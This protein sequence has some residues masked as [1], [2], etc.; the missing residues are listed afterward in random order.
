MS[1][2]KI[3][4]IMSDAFIIGAVVLFLGAFGPVLLGELS[5]SAAK[6][7]DFGWQL[8]VGN[9]YANNTSSNAVGSIISH[10]P[11]TLKPA[12]LDSSIVIEKIGVSAPVVLNV[13]VTDE[14]AYKEALKYGVAHAKGSALPGENGNAYIFAHSSINFWELGKY[15]TVFNLLNKLEAGD[16]IVLFYN[17]QRFDYEV[18]DNRVV[19]GWNT[20]PI[21][22]QTTYPILTLQTCDPPGT[23]INRRIVTAKLVA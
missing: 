12:N 16:R 17:K 22:R 14:A 19:S 23:V 15:A 2:S 20:L 11:L 13:P 18:V 4:K 9:D 6:I 10:K 7:F 5:Y 8:P 3:L 1:Y 21:L